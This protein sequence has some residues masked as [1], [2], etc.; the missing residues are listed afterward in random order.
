M[1]IAKVKRTVSFKFGKSLRAGT[2]VEVRQTNENTCLVRKNNS[3][4]NLE[5][6]V[7]KDSLSKV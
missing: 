4:P 6:L 1:T 5:Y 2:L 3:E 7:M